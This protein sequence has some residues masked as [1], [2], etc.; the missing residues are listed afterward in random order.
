[1]QCDCLP[2]DKWRSDEHVLTREERR[3]G[4]RK[5]RERRRG[6]KGRVREG[7]DWERGERR[8][9]KR[10]GERRPEGRERNK[11]RERGGEMEE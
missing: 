9:E 7:L 10:R 6:K 2:K 3:K 1:M 5:E 8:E 11:E 4:S